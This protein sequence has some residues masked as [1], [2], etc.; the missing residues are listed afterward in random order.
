MWDQNSR[1]KLAVVVVNAEMAKLE[2]KK[3]FNYRLERQNVV[4]ILH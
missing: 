3:K 4:N 1:Q 2:E